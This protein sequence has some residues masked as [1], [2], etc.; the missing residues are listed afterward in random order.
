MATENSGTD[1]EPQAAASDAAG[2]AGDPDTERLARR[3]LPQP[4]QLRILGIAGVALLVLLALARLA[5]AFGGA[6]ADAPAAAAAPGTFRIADAQLASLTIQPVAVLPFR[7]EHITD[8]RIALNAD[9]TTPVYSPY[10]GRVVRV[11][12]G[13]GERVARGAPLLAIEASEFVQ[14]QSDLSNAGAQLQLAQ[15]NEQRRHAAYEARGA[16]LQDWQQAQSD[17]AVAQAAV[18]AAR[19]RLRILG[20]SDAEIDALAQAPDTAGVTFLKA[21]ISGVVTDRQ[22][23]PGQYLQSGSGTAVFTIAD[24]ST[25]WLVANV[26]EVDAP[27][28]AA[29]QPVEVRV[30]ALPNEVFLATLSTVG[31]TVDPGTRRV[32][33]R[34]VL[35][36]RYGRLKPEMFATFSIVT[37]APRDAPGVPEEAVIYEGERARVWVVN[38]DRSVAL[39]EITVGRT[40]N[41]MVEI[42]SGLRAGEQVVTRGSLFIDRAARPG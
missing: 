28:I 38:R 11:I 10:S 12:A 36:N 34:A 21:P 39:R 30:L 23:G 3:T 9:T 19:K 17:L 24:L 20:K 6:P 8:G 33:V 42:L 41:G 37:S 40:Q 4:V 5:G 1:P 18:N 25:V 13:I 27:G 7:T 14:G 32:A 16:S 15:V 29:G 35:D 2:A 26:R 31:P 22:V